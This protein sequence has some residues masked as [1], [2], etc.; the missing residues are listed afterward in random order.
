MQASYALAGAAAAAARKVVEEEEEREGIARGADEAEASTSA[1]APAAA[2]GAKK[3]RKD[4]DLPGGPGGSSL[5]E[6]RA[7]ALRAFAEAMPRRAGVYIWKTA[8]GDKGAVLYVGKANN[9]RSRV[10]SYLAAAAPARAR[11]MVEEAGAVDFVLTPGGCGGRTQL[12][13]SPVWAAPVSACLGD[14]LRARLGY[15]GVSTSA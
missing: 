11:A 3:Q 5:G 7:A 13:W 1:A 14:S 8:P 10:S 9:L 2:P 4:R 15:C 6:E 12:L